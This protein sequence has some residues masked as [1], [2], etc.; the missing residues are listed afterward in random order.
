MLQPMEFLGK[1]PLIWVGLMRQHGR[2]NGNLLVG[3][4]GDR[5]LTVL[6]LD[7][8]RRQFYL[9]LIMENLYRTC[10]FSHTYNL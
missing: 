8:S 1:S 3:I 4:I 9:E 2:V 10:A 7:I 5:I 6:N